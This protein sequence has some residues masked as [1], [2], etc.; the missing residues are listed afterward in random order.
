MSMPHRRRLLTGGFR[1]G[2]LILF[3]AMLVP[4]IVVVGTSFA[5]SSL[6]RFPPKS[7]SLKWYSAFL[8]D[9]AWLQAVKNSIIAGVGTTVVATSLGLTGA[10]GVQRSDSTFVNRLLPATL[11]PLFIPPVVLGVALLAFFGSFSL[12]QTYVS[13]I[14]AHSLWAVPIAFLIIQS[15][16]TQVDWNLRDAALDLGASPTRTFFEVILPQI[17]AGLF[18]SMLI[19]FIIS[20][21]EFVMTLF[22]AGNDTRT[23]PVLAWISISQVL[24]PVVSVVSTLLIAVVTLSLLGAVSLIG[25]DQ[26]ARQF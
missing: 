23:I 1:V 17:K 6:F 7:L 3:L 12:H 24:D 14:V 18:A 26:L 2:Y 15:V 4:L 9:K 22:V 20:L 5:Q 11:M 21:Q 10:Y 19:A 25:L 8:H 16:M 13:I